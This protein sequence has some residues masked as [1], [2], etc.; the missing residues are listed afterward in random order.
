MPKSFVAR[1]SKAAFSD[2]G[3]LVYASMLYATVGKDTVRKS[4]ST[5]KTGLSNL[6][7]DAEQCRFMPAEAIRQDN[8]RIIKVRLRSIR[9]CA[10]SA[11]RNVKMRNRGM[12]MFYDFVTL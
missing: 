3:K 1:N 7:L 2:S 5:N 9:S 11:K 10:C 4:K 6:L 12:L 8:T